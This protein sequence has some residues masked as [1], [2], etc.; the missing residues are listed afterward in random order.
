MAKLLLVP[1]HLDA[2]YL[3]EDQLMTEPLADF[4]RLPFFNGGRDV[5]A[6]VASLSEN[7]VSPAL[8]NQNLRYRAGLHLH[9]AL[10]DALTKGKH[11][12]SAEDPERYTAV[13]PSV[14]NRWIIIK[15]DDQGLILKKWLVESDFF[16][17]EEATIA[18]EIK[19]A[20]D[21]VR[22]LQNELIELRKQLQSED[23]DPIAIQQ[24]IDDKE[25]ALEAIL[26]NDRKK[27]ITYPIKVDTTSAKQPFRYMGRQ[28]EW[29]KWEAELANPPATPHDY[30][31]AM[32]GQTLTAIGYGEP[33]FAA[34][35]PNCRSVFGFH[36]ADFEGDTTAVRYA[37]IG[38]YD[39]AKNDFLKGLMEGK[40]ETEFEEIL[41]N[42]ASW[43]ASSNFSGT[44]FPGQCVLFAQLDFM[45]PPGEAAFKSFTDSQVAIANTGREALAAYLANAILPVPNTKDIRDTTNAL[46]EAELN[47]EEKQGLHKF[48]LIGDDELAAAEELASKLVIDL[49][50]LHD[51]AER[52]EE[53]NRPTRLK[54]EEQLEALFLTDQ[55]D[56][57]QLDVGAKFKEARH[58]NGF[59]ALDTGRLWAV[60]AIS[61]NGQDAQSL[62]EAE[63]NARPLP[64]T[65]GDQLKRV[66]GL[67]QI[68]DQAQFRMSSRKQQ[69][70][71]DWYKYILSTYP[72]E[73][74]R[75]DFPDIDELRYFI[76][77]KDLKPLRQNL[78][79]TGQLILAAKQE[80]TSS[81]DIAGIQLNAFTSK[82]VEEKSDEFALQAAN[83]DPTYTFDMEA[84]VA[85]D[86]D[87]LKDSLAAQLALSINALL[88]TLENH[89][90]D[91]EYSKLKLE[92][93]KNWDELVHT[94]LDPENAEATSSFDEEDIELV[95]ALR[96]L[97]SD[98]VQ[99]T[100][101]DHDSNSSWT[102]SEREAVINGIN[103]LIETHD[104]RSDTSEAL[105]RRAISRLNRIHLETILPGLIRPILRTQLVL[106]RIIAPRYWQPKEPVVL[107]AGE[108]AKA[109]KRFA[110][111]GRLNSG[112]LECYEAS[113]GTDDESMIQFSAATTL[114]EDLLRDIEAL[115][116]SG[117][118][119]IGFYE[120]TDQPWN[121]FM[122]EW[123]A[124]VCPLQ[125]GSN[126]R[127]GDYQMDYA[128]G[129]TILK[130][131]AEDLEV[132]PGKSKV[133]TGRNPNIYNGRSLL[134]FHAQKSMKEQIDA[135]LEEHGDGDG[136]N[137]FEDARNTFAHAND[138]LSKT[139]TLSQS[140]SGFN[141]ALLMLKQTLQMPVD[142]PIGFADYEGFSDEV[143]QM[144]GANTKMSPQPL[145]DFTPIR[146]G[147]LR[148]NQLRV[149]DTF[150]QYRQLNF[151]DPDNGVEVMGSSLLAASANS[152]ESVVQIPLPM[153]L[154]QAARVN[155]RWL[156]ANSNQDQMN[157]IRETAP[158]CGWLMVNFLDQSIMVYNAAGK[159]L[160]AIE[161]EEDLSD[162]TQAK[163]RSAP[164]L[165]VES[166]PTNIEN[167]HLEQM[168]N[169][170][171]RQGKQFVI[172]FINSSDTIM[173]S[174]EPETFERQ[175]AL[176]L[177]MGRPMA[178]VRA[179]LDLE[180]KGVP[181]L[182]QGW[183]SFY[184]DRQ[185]GD[186]ERETDLYT[187]V[188]FHI[189]LGVHNQFNDGLVGFWREEQID[190]GDDTLSYR[191]LED[192]FHLNAFQGDIPSL[193]GSDYK[194]PIQFLQDETPFAQSLDDS[195]EYVSLLID[196]R[197]K[198][199]VATGILPMKDI[200]I[201][202]H[203]FL[204]A[205]QAIDVSFLTSP[206]L[207]PPEKIHV[208]VPEHEGFD[209]CWVEKQPSN[210]NGITWNEII[211]QPTIS[212]STL[213]N[214][215]AELIWQTILKRNWISIN[216]SGQA[217]LVQAEDRKPLGAEFESVGTDIDS[218]LSSLSPL[219][220]DNFAAQISQSGGLADVLWELMTTSGTTSWLVLDDPA[221]ETARVRPRKER[222][223]DSLGE[224][225]DSPNMVGLEE[226]IS[227]LLHNYQSGIQEP[228]SRADF[229]AGRTIENGDMKIKDR[230]TMLWIREGWLKLKKQES[231]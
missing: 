122:F 115:R 57:R 158:I 162:N 25:E 31:E 69:L 223:P 29:A 134:T 11:Q 145:T 126:A 15:E 51:D 183:E 148:L 120:W 132:R 10:P 116:R 225:G 60:R 90:F 110:Q 24:Q 222:Q 111:D 190:N 136:T 143:S 55:L 47:L 80:A 230:E 61:D 194:G 20:I 4:S 65:L 85:A 229:F 217:S 178:L 129:N 35:Y 138:Q 44:D 73:D 17:P 211:S 84:E 41:K 33:T 91:L 89:N 174:I 68:Y 207:S 131:N 102:S 19:D 67:Q 54:I 125:E 193:A 71:T 212:K 210:G 117:T 106:K 146:S 3:Q 64:D 99:Q 38:W 231:A 201:P 152:Q 75:V 18:Q 170:I 48:G 147:E 196:P 8:Q 219:T 70:F 58:E 224:E 187:Q 192:T 221:A 181:A 112:L 121:P 123:E 82:T 52:F 97:L 227:A 103:D 165:A 7:M 173:D 171:R 66:N 191:Y 228:F 109:S 77:E 118:E 155:F 144:I 27:S 169:Y 79:N 185:D 63:A 137:D 150:G 204:E 208:H 168:V 119:Q 36:D 78:L 21:E 205:M 93:V 179:S 142:D 176:A 140:L 128:T 186:D 164:G 37:V 105:S 72:P 23:V 74:T 46:Q 153:R 2:M 107:I 157:S 45:T 213:Q 12:P 189:R 101:R 203:Q 177:L 167:P 53:S 202:D 40:S 39:N 127:D 149:V 141:A 200:D 180:L 62:T 188:K 199:H 195:A 14:P 156:D 42:K 151:F 163:W 5:N 218:I 22:D 1:I 209:W 135:Y 220:L 124:E 50:K 130:V 113:A 81:P 34:F 161:A 6:D 215:F 59:K 175:Q 32:T 172:D 16:W 206:I 28:L 92:E 160:G 83:L 26:K 166:Q 87:P 108:I 9:W 88:D 86:F 13:F 226:R 154:A 98:E 159:S 182:H 30:L 133:I 43:E 94:I 216:P 96:N 76:T 95:N 214:R 104:F 56:H 184:R 197:A 198:V 139:H 114:A 100:M 49:E